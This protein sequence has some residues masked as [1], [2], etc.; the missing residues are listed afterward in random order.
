MPMTKDLLADLVM[1]TPAPAVLLI[2][3]LY[4]GDLPAREVLELDFNARTKSRLRTRLASG[5]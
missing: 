4:D 5:A 3:S 2:E 1:P